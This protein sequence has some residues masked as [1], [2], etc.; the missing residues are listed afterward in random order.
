M[1]TLPYAAPC[2]CP[3]R[4]WHILP[5]S[6]T[7]HAAIT[8]AALLHCRRLSFF[9]FYYAGHID[10]ITLF[11]YGMGFI[12]RYV[13]HYYRYYYAIHYAII[14][15]LPLP[16]WC[17]HM[18]LRLR[19]AFRHYA[20]PAPCH[21]ADITYAIIYAISATP[22]MLLPCCCLLPPLLPRHYA[23]ITPLSMSCCH[24]TRYCYYATIT[25][26]LRLMP[27]PHYAYASH[28]RHTLTMILR[29]HIRWLLLILLFAIA[30]TLHA[31]AIMAAS[32]VVAELSLLLRH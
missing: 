8:Y 15:T 31:G 25:L 26:P 14:I 23:D 28:C 3:P 22:Q 29:Y 24:I 7:I 4:W 10:A 16:Y 21:A 12:R 1:H 20:T 9:L 2:H 17:C 19:L 11:R 30:A 6:A 18:P 27:S 13:S 32:F 5:S